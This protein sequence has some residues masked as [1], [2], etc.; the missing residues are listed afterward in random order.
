MEQKKNGREISRPLPFQQFASE[1]LELVSESRRERATT[2]IGDPRI[3]ACACCEVQIVRR[4]W[5]IGIEDIF[6]TERDCRIAEASV[7]CRDVV[8]RVVRNIRIEAHW[9][10]T[11]WHLILVARGEALRYRRAP[12]AACVCELRLMFPAYE[13]ITRIPLAGGFDKRLRHKDT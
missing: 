12:R 13:Q 10:H 1:L 3:P 7:G 2:R 5:W 11:R 8:Q 9:Y 6:Y 4:K